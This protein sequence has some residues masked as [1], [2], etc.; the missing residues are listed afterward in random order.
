MSQ[1]VSIN[2]K[3]FLNDYIDFGSK[4]YGSWVQPDRRNY[5]TSKC[6]VHIWQNSNNLLDFW[7]NMV[8]AHNHWLNQN[9]DAKKPLTTAGYVT[10]VYHHRKSGVNLKRYEDEGTTIEKALE[11]QELRKIAAITVT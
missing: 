11:V 5:P 8:S 3:N 4:D 10:R 7:D 1:I 2:G 6:L 9:P